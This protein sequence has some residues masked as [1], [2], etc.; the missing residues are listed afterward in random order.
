[1]SLQMQE[2][3]GQWRELRDIHDFIEKK[4]K[5]HSAGTEQ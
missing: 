1:M 4:K 5:A 2:A 3:A